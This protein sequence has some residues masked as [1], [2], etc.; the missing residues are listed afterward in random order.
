[1]VAA[2]KFVLSFMTR[3]ERTVYFVLV[4]GRALSAILDVVGM[5]LIGLIAGLAT[6]QIQ[7]SGAGTST[8]FGFAVP[9]FSSADLIWL[10]GVALAVFVAKSVVS[11]LLTRALV[12]QL[13]AIEMRAATEIAEHLVTGSLDAMKGLSRSETQYAIGQS[14]YYGISSLLTQVASILSEGFLL[15]LILATFVVID[16]IAAACAVVYFALIIFI[17]QVVI[18]RNMTHLGQEFHRGIVDTDDLVGN[19]IDAF[20]EI[21]VLGKQAEFVRRVQRQRS[22]VAYSGGTTTLLSGMPRYVIETALILGVVLFIGVQVAT[23]DLATGVATLGVFLAGGLRIVS[24]LL[25]LQTA[26]ANLRIVAQAGELAYRQLGDEGRKQLDRGVPAIARDTASE[27]PL[28]VRISAVTFRYPGAD[29]DSIRGV[30]LPVE[31]GSF[32]AII[33]P[34]GA[35][36]TTLVDLLLGIVEPREGDVLI[37][38]ESPAE[39]RRKAP[40]IV[41]YVPQRPGLVSGT[42]AE[43]IALGVPAEQIDREQVRRSAEAA[44]LADFIATLPD[45]Y[46][47][48]VGKQADAFSGGQIQRIGLARALYTEPRLLILD[49]ATSALDAGSEAVINQSLESLRGRTTVVVIAHRLSTVQHAD[50]LFVVEG[51]RITAS[52]DFASVRAA[53]P[54]VDEYVKLMTITEI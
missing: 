40:G 7:T 19:V 43:N 45:G 33:G 41:A 20:R 27:Q 12:N 11:I 2:V 3:R 53:V 35:G 17:M 31:A 47:T 4:G 13:A 32:T 39:L 36:K 5:L 28:D 24:S 25:P 52:G 50:V 22:R 21:T 44:H 38:G 15:L 34:S 23:G 49:E 6:Q 48:P 42:I 30:D 14:S 54:M 18:H 8:V 10:A 26:L 37:G 29:A 46:D 51:G 9:A 16:P 1:M